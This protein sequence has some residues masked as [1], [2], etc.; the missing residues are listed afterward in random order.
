MFSS[1][2]QS[3]DFKNS[4]GKITKPCYTVLLLQGF[5]FFFQLKHLKIEGISEEQQYSIH[6]HQ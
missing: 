1:F 6:S 5:T 3:G 4:R 2:K